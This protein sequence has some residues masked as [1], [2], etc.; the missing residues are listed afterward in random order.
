MERPLDLE[1]G[2]HHLLVNV[3]CGKRRKN[4]NLIDHRERVKSRS[5]PAQHWRACESMQHLM[6]TFWGLLVS[7]EVT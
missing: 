1:V 3:L 7:V 6:V 4:S 2:F 5:I